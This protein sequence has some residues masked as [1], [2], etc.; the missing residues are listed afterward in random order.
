MGMCGEGYHYWELLVGTTT[1]EH[2]CTA[3]SGAD[4][5]LTQT[6]GEVRLLLLR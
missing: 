4:V 2:A 3:G 5:S 6:M 1:E